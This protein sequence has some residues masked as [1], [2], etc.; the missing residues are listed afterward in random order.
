MK[1]YSEA[2]ILFYLFKIGQGQKY[3][4]VDFTDD[5]C[6]LEYNCILE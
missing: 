3:Y 2:V 6:I 1:V 4:V 5:S